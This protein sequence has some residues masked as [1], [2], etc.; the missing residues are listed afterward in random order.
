MKAMERLWVFPSHPVID[1]LLPFPVCFAEM[2]QHL[3]KLAFHEGVTQGGMDWLKS[4]Q[5]VWQKIVLWEDKQVLG[6]VKSIDHK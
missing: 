3:G 4:V 6:T 5:K 2:L 1:H